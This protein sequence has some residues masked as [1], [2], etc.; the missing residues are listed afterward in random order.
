MPRPNLHIV[1]G[2]FG[3]S[4]K[5]IAQRLL[6]AGLDVRTLTNSPGRAHSFGD[7]V[8]VRPLAFTQPDQLAASLEG[9]TVLYNTYWVRFNHRTFTRSEAVSNTLA[10]FEAAHRAGVQRIVHV[11][12]TK[13][14]EDSP[15]EYFRSKA[16][17]ERALG[18]TGIPMSD[19]H[20]FQTT[21]GLQSFH[22]RAQGIEV[23]NDRSIRAP[24]GALDVGANGTASGQFVF[25]AETF[26]FIAGKVH[27]TRGM[28]I[29]WYFTQTF[30]LNSA[31]KGGV[32]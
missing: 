14:S 17:L 23:G 29:C 11:S 25:D 22:H 5:Y 27:N 19:G 6:D 32:S 21:I 31:L 16:Q 20:N 2:A 4:G 10:L 12:I 3:Y 7:A 26:E 9:A 13:P 1:T 15:F 18:E 24:L 30:S 8:E 28:T